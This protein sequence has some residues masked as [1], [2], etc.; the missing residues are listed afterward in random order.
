MSKLIPIFVYYE[1]CCARNLSG[2]M[3]MFCIL[4]ESTVNSFQ[5]SSQTLHLRP[6]H[7]RYINHT[8]FFKIG[9]ETC[10]EEHLIIKSFAN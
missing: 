1:S 6:V 9:K 5:N 4:T 3:D 7:F 10:C 2:V 8:S